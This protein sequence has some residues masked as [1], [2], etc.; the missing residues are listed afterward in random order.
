MLSLLFKCS[1][2]FV[3]NYEALVIEW[4]IK[5]VAKS[6]GHKFESHKEPKFMFSNFILNLKF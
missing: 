3:F 2:R 1:V 6:R 4:F 5:L